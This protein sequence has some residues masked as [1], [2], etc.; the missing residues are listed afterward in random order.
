MT[1][2]SNETSGAEKG[3]SGGGFGGRRRGFGGARL[4]LVDVDGQ[5]QWRSQLG[6][7]LLGVLPDLGLFAA[8]VGGLALLLPRRGPLRTRTP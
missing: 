8:G 7:F 6:V 3:A 2:P 1:G 5:G 4:G